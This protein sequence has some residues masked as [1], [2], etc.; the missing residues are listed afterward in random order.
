[1]VRELTLQ[2]AHFSSFH[3]CAYIYMLLKVP[4]SEHKCHKYKYIYRKN[5][6]LKEAKLLDFGGKHLQL[7]CSSAIATITNIFVH[8][9]YFSISFL[10]AYL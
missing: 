8:G 4:I 2:A 7:L 9:S 1:M 10:K 3:L 5:W 6:N